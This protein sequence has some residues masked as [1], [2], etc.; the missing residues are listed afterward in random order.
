MDSWISRLNPY[1]YSLW[2]T[3]NAN[4]LDSLRQREDN[5][6]K[7]DCRHL[8]TTEIFSQD[9]R[10]PQKQ[11]VNTSKLVYETREA[12]SREEIWTLNSRRREDSFAIKP[13]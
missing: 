1:C 9:A 11:K 3:L 5:I 7:Q 8:Q 12:N 13:P 6:Q 4:N 10:S 2:K